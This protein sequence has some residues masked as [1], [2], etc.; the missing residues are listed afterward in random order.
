MRF[1]WPKR[2]GVGGTTVVR[3]LVILAAVG[4][5]LAGAAYAATRRL[6]VRR[7]LEQVPEVPI[8]APAY[9]GPRHGVVEHP[10]PPVEHR[11]HA[12]R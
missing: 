5:C 10:L 3:T 12:L 4:F 7:L 11:L 9:L 8:G 1:G 2:S 6:P